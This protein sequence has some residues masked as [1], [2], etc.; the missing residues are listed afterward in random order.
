MRAEQHPARQHRIL[1]LAYGMHMLQECCDHYTP[2]CNARSG[3]T[4]RIRSTS[5][6]VVRFAPEIG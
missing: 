2:I 5:A 4:F 3:M 6:S 1:T